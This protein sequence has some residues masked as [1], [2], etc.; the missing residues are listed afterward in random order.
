M[1]Q[2]LR[3]LVRATALGLALTSSA[4]ATDLE[5]VLN[6]ARDADPEFAAAQRTWQA[7]QQAVK[8]GRGALMPSINA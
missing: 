1:H 8:Q 2:H 5:D 6:A 4:G 3:Y 7:D